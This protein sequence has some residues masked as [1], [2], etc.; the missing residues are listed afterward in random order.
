MPPLI[1]GTPIAFPL[2]GFLVPCRFPSV[3]TSWT[4]PAFLAVLV[5]VA[6]IGAFT[7]TIFPRPSAVA[8]DSPDDLGLT[9]SVAPATFRDGDGGPYSETDDTYI[10]S[11]AP[12]TNFGTNSKLLVDGAGCKISS[13]AVCKTLIKFPNFIG[14][15]SGQVPPGSTI[16]SAN[17]DLVIT[18]KGW[19]QDVYQVTESWREDSAT[20]NSFSPAGMPGT[21]PQ[22]SV[23]S[24]R[25]LGLFSIDITSIVQHWVGGEPNEGVLLASSNS[26]GV[27]YES[28]ESASPPALTV[29]FTAPPSSPPSEF[30]I[31]DLGTL[32]GGS[33]ST[34]SAI[35]DAGQVVGS[36]Q[37]SVAGSAEW[38]A[39]LWDDGMMTD[40]GVPGGGWLTF[41]PEAINNGGQVVGTSRDSDG[42]DGA[43]RWEAGVW[44]PV[45]RESPGDIN[46]AGQI[47]GSGDGRHGAPVRG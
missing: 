33:S 3:R 17:L 18:N 12:G 14:P 10:S 8:I 28:S 37:I 16:E 41:L 13:T 26:D 21:K 27:D 43:W 47:V 42:G 24:P 45:A 38:Q 5:L 7:P 25:S 30:M 32:P 36:S 1:P 19:T 39:V 46:D 6:G 34:A 35:N 9:A 23:I 20:W 44:T 40:L 2:E 4:G 15:N 11:G 29:Q 31:I 22:D